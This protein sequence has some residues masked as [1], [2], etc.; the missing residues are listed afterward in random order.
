MASGDRANA[1]NLVFET[2]AEH[3]TTRVPRAAPNA[4]A[5]LAFFMPGVVYLADAVGAQ[6]ETLVIRGLSVGVSL[7]QVVWRELPTGLLVGLS[8]SAAFYPVALW[9]W[10]DTDLTLTVSMSL[11]AACATASLVAMSLPWA[12]QRLHRD[13]AFGSGPLATVVQGILSILIYLVLSMLL[14]S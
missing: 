6:T 3:L 13:P 11:L 5:G 1:G 14:I 4:E 7:R 2:A 12:F 10:Q 8:L 9:L